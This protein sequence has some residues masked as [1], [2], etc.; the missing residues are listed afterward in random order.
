MSWG[1]NTGGAKAFQDIYLDWAVK[2]LFHTVV[3]SVGNDGIG[4]SVSSP[5][6]GWNI[7]AVGSI[8]DNDNGNW[9]GDTMSS[10]SS[11]LNPLSGQ[12]KPD[13]V[14][15]GSDITT[16]SSNTQSSGDTY[17]NINGT[18]F[19]GPEVA[20]QVALMIARQPFQ[21]IWPETNR[22]AVLA[23]AFHDVVTSGRDQDG[24]GAV[25]M[26]A[27]DNAYR[28]NQFRNNSI[29]STTTDVDNV[30][31]LTAGQVVRVAIA[32]DSLSNGSNS[33]ILGTDLDLQIL[34]PSGTIL[35]SSA[36]INNSEEVVDFT[37]PT[38][39]NYTFRIH[40]FGQDPSFSFTYV[41]TAWTFK[42]IPSLCTSAVNVAA[43]GGTFNNVSTANGGT[44]IDSYPGVSWNESG[45]EVIYKLTTT[46]TKN[47]AV[48]D[49]NSSLDLFIVSLPSNCLSTVAGNP[50]V[51][52][53][54]SNTASYVFAPPGTY[55]IIAD[56]FNGA[57]G[58]TN[59]TISVTP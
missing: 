31:A 30:V 20:G 37:V 40:K 58:T 21:R 34:N 23:S 52:A 43:G 44:Y 18:S 42:S 27:S 39:G 15:V 13:V 6:L 17:F 59:L 29:N 56:G 11:T 1:G 5:A 35:A 38:T 14:A 26:V 10:F 9:A 3:A 28:L 47:I 50:T 16:T 24:F 45:R 4:A 55:Y 25:M 41:G 51:R 8:D 49:T 12:E 36:S 57:V 32:W 22:A 53:F 19:S 48:S 46:A 7:I 54:G 2:N 33:D